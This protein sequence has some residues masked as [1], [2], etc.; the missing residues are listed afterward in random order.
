MRRIVVLALFLLSA[1]SPL[2]TSAAEE[3]LPDSI[4]EG[5]KKVTVDEVRSGKVIVVVL[6]GK[7][8]A[9]TL[10]GVDAPDAKVKPKGECYAKEATDYVTELLP[11]ETE[12]YLEED[13]FKTDDDDREVRFV[14]LPGEN[15]E[16]PVLVNGRL[17]RQG[18]AAWQE[19]SDN[20]RYEKVFERYEKEAKERERGIWK[21]C[22]GPH[23]RIELSV[24]ERKAEYAQLADVREL[25]IRPGGMLGQR[26]MFYGSILDIAVA[27][28]GRV[29]ILGDEDPKEYAAWIEVWV[30][31][32][33]GSVEPVSVGFNGDTAGMFKDSY[34]VVYG[35]VVGTVSGTNGF[36]GAITHPLLSAEFVE[37]A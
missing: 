4:P 17:I 18:Y 7:R 26:I 12:V 27:P 20:T 35:T 14:W 19:E 22:G 3:A 24:E 28:P 5:A 1:A 10:I 32:P 8:T 29:F 6:N 33:D 9:I 34:I 2:A 30:T 37:L 25:A 13:E 31:A 36:G 21:N 11:K 23:K 16:K 15:D